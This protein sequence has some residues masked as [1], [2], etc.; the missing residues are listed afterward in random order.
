MFEPFPKIAR[1]SREV[2]ITEKIDGT[3]AQ[4]LIEEAQT[5]VSDAAIIV[6]GMSVCAGSRNRWITPGKGT[7]NHGF[8]MWVHDNARELVKL[9]PGRHFGEWWGQGIQRGYGLTEKRFS[10]FNVSRWGQIYEAHVAGHETAFP[11][12]CYLVPVLAR[13]AVDAPTW[14]G[15]PSLVEDAMTALALR[16]SYA[17]PGF[18]KP[19]GIIIFHTANGALYKKTF[20]HDS[21]GKEAAQA[22][23]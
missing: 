5:I 2:I 1:W 12:C 4:V 9:G 3:N 22:A 21:A 11:K 15:S 8:A 10:L 14:P 7:D 17:S 16:G 18:G 19:E 13:G 20:E 6:E 23:A